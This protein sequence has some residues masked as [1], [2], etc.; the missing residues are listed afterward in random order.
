MVTRNI[1]FQ[2]ESGIQPIVMNEKK[3]VME[4]PKAKCQNNALGTELDSY[5]RS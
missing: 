5:N 4:G 2:N 1:E 3:N